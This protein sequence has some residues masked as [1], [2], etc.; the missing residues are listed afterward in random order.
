MKKENWEK[1]H[2]SSKSTSF[3]FPQCQLFLSLETLHL[4]DSKQPNPNACDPIQ[5]AAS[6]AQEDN[7]K[8][9]RTA[10]SA[11]LYRSNHLKSRRS[12]NDRGE[13]RS[14]IMPS[15]RRRRHKPTPR[16]IHS[17]K[18]TIIAVTNNDTRRTRRRYSRHLSNRTS[19]PGGA[20]YHV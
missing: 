9:N 7:I 20:S 14:Q 19:D 10:G 16:P 3:G 1:A 17:R 18:S 8:V 2:L 4:A 11:R 13:S 5:R 12:H 6:L 15:P